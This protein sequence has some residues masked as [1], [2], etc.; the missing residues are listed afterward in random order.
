MAA[1]VTAYQT[2]RFDQQQLLNNY[3]LDLNKGLDGAVPKRNIH[4]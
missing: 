2:Y 3:K 4:T 1:E